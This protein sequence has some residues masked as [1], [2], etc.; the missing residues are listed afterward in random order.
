MEKLLSVESARNIILE[1]FKVKNSVQLPINQSL[2][3]I[4]SKDIFAILNL[5]P[6]N[7]SS[8]DGF[9]VLSDN[10]RDASR[11]KVRG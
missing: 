9:A 10:V 5:P 2:G 7:N 3:K 11:E 6:F 1:K 4:L 8:M